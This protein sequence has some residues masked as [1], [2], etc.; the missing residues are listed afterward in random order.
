VLLKAG[1]Y[2]AQATMTLE[3]LITHQLNTQAIP[4]LEKE[5]EKEFTMTDK[6]DLYQVLLLTNKITNLLRNKLHLFHLEIK[7][8]DLELLNIKFSLQVLDN[9]K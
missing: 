7:N 1:N 4:N 2:L 5:R 8:R 6:L 9:I 3:I